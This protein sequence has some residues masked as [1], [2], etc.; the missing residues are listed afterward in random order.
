LI[1]WSKRS[2]IRLRR[3]LDYSRIFEA[4]TE[5]SANE[6]DNTK[7]STKNKNCKKYYNESNTTSAIRNIT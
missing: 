7:D 3:S 1:L 5:S 4:F 2:I 6:K